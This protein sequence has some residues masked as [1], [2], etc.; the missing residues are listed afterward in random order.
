MSWKVCSWYNLR[1]MG[2]RSQT[3]HYGYGS[4]YLTIFKT[5][6]I[7]TFNRD[8]ILFGEENI[9]RQCNS[10]ISN[11]T[12]YVI[13]CFW[14]LLLAK[15]MKIKILFVFLLKT[16]LM[17]NILFIQYLIP[18]STWVLPWWP[19]AN[20]RLSSRALLETLP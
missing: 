1:N 7:L 19:G 20:H 5:I 8:G 3:K 13:Q 11:P 15:S 16:M 6:R 18:N 17:A 4:L 10:E 9:S 12:F 2:A 14:F